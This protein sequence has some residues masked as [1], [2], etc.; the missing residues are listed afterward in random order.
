MGVL[1]FVTASADT[2][3]VPSVYFLSRLPG[4]VFWDTTNRN[5]NFFSVAHIAASAW[6]YLGFI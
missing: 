6:L 5:Q 4:P 2:A 1:G 3:F